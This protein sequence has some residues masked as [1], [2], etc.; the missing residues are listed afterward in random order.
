MGKKYRYY[1][2]IEDK[3]I[4]PLALIIVG[5]LTLFFTIGN[6]LWFDLP[7]TTIFAGI[8]LMLFVAF[9]IWGV[10]IFQKKPRGKLFFIWAIFFLFFFSAVFLFDVL[11][12][13]SKYWARVFFLMP[14]LLV[15]GF[16]SYVYKLIRTNSITKRS[17]KYFLS[18]LIIFSLCT[19]YTHEFF[20]V[21]YV[22]LTKRQVGGAIWYSKH[23]EDKNVIVTEFGFNY[24]FMYYDYP[25]SKGDKNLRGRDIDYFVDAGENGLFQPEN[26]TDKVDG[27]ELRDLKEDNE[28]DV[29]LTP[30]EQYFKHEG[31]ETYGYLD[32]E[33]IQA[34]YDANYLNKIYSARS[35][36]GKENA[37]YW[38]I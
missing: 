33:D 35:E 14:P 38:V 11:S 9:G 34:Y 6:F 18:F 32:K 37:Y 23:T 3:I 20:T 15:V 21:Q 28:T 12:T 31:W 8:E 4:I 24:M 22:S 29:V 7:I 2:T 36:N 27:D 17:T 26:Q 19:T 1:K 30:D 25:Y 5:V 13:N 10:L 16:I